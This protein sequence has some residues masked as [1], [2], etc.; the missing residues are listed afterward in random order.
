M[1]K[2]IFSGTKILRRKSKSW[3]RLSN[4]TKKA[5]LKTATSVD[6]SEF[7]KKVELANSKSNVD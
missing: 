3:I 6:T 1:K 2:W 5:D 4:Y 7:A